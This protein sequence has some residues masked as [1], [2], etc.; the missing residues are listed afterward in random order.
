MW[1]PAHITDI[2]NNVTTAN[3]WVWILLLHCFLRLCCGDAF[4]TDTLLQT[5]DV[6][7]RNLYTE[8][9]LCADTLT[10]RGL[11]TDKLLHADAFTQRGFYAKKFYTQKFL[12]TD[13]LHKYAF[14]HIN[15]GTQALLHTEPFTQR[16][17]CTEQ[18]LHKETFTQESFDAEQFAHTD[19]TKKFL[20]TETFTRRNFTQRSF[21]TENFSAQKPLRTE[22]FIHSSFYTDSFTHRCLYTEKKSHTEASAHSTLLHTASF[23]TERLCFPFLITFDHLPFVSPLSSTVI[24]SMA[25]IIAR[26]GWWTIKRMTWWWMDRNENLGDETPWVTWGS[27]VCN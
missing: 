17:L 7:H 8:Q 22:V 20:Q 27:F 6:T 26:I 14:T 16:N 2:I 18:L 21:Y 19:C 23:Y 15:K 25:H 12:Y 4:C 3:I 5:D 11:C 10:Q 9:L 1:G 13:A 24:K